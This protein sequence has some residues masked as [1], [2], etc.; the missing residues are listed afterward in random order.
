MYE[1]LNKNYDLNELSN[2][3]NQNLKKVREAIKM[4]VDEEGSST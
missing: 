1:V 3:M 4:K 2:V